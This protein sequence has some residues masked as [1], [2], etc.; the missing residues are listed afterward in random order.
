MPSVCYLRT[1]FAECNE[2][3]RD[4]RQA[5]PAFTAPAQLVHPS[6]VRHQRRRPLR[7]PRLVVEPAEESE[8]DRLQE[9]L[10]PQ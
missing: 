4:H 1:G 5:W 3:R 6:N 2:R 10:S 9:L 7:G 8:I